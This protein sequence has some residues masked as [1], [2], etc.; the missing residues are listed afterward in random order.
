MEPP[1][2]IRTCNWVSKRGLDTRMKRTVQRQQ[3][4]VR[5]LA[6]GCRKSKRVS[7]LKSSVFSPSLGGRCQQYNTLV[8]GS[9][10]A[11]VSSLDRQKVQR[12]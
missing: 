2:A 3:T 11:S 10:A 9:R 7:R 4:P 12:K 6:V 8:T 1:V 5:C